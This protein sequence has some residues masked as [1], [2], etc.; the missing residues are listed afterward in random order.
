MS[1]IA[2]L[3]DGQLG[4]LTA[5]AAQEMWHE[6]MVFWDVW[7][8]SPAGQVSPYTQIQ[9]KEKFNPE[10]I[11]AS[12]WKV[13]E[14]DPDVTTIEW[15]NVP[16]NFADATEKTGITMRPGAW[17][18][19]AIQDRKTE[20]ETVRN[21]W[22]STVEFEDILSEEDLREAYIDLGPWIIKT[23]REGYDGKGQFR[24]EN[25]DDI[26]RFIMLVKSG[27]ERPFWEIG[28]IYEQLVDF[29]Y[30]ISVTVLRNPRW[31]MTTFEPAHNTHKNGI[32]DTSFIPA[33]HSIPLQGRITQDVVDEAKTIAQWIAEHMWLVWEFT[34]E[35]FVVIGKDWKPR[36]IVNEIA[37]RPHNSG[38]GTIE[39]YSNINQYSGLIMAI[40][41]QDL[42]ESADLEAHTYLKNMMWNDI[43]FIPGR[44]S[45][46]WQ[47]QT[48]Y[49][50]WITTTYY[51]Y[52]KG[53]WLK[54]GNFPEWRKMGHMTKVLWKI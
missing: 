26:N 45:Q 46:E 12:V 19:K 20:K 17:I 9:I 22:F 11:S 35:M 21:A 32:L 23:R 8:D 6:T 3:G 13:L 54:D 33:I 25:N 15:E 40:L 38:H 48:T 2:I 49:D 39:S 44:M 10:I 4:Q 43:S 51:D 31:Q 29:D 5:L 27:T 53:K 24:V 50:S 28:R 41:D 37:P 30:E 34:V 52:G 1:K 14:F 7:P 36:L 47:G 16:A 42:L 18:L